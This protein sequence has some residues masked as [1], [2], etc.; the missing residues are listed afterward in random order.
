MITIKDVAERAG[1][2]VATVSRVLNHDG[3]VSAASRQKVINAAETL[4]Y[5]PNLLGR[6]LR[7]KRTNIILVMLASLSNTFCAKVIRGIEK[8]ARQNGYQVLISATGYDTAVEQTDLD[9]VR[10]RLADGVIVLNSTLS[11]EAISE[12]SAQYPLVQCNEYTDTEKTPYISID[13]FAAGYEATTYLLNSGRRHIAF[14]GV[15]E[16]NVS[17]RLRYEGYVKAL[18][19]YGIAPDQRLVFNSNYGYRHTEKV[20]RE[21]LGTKAAFDGLF[22]ISDTMAAAALNT[23]KQEGICVPQDVAVVGFDDTEIAYMTEPALTTIAQPRSELGREALLM[24]LERMNGRPVANRFLQHTLV[25][26]TSA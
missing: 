16:Q 13:N 1:V 10:K 9:L 25:K 3:S 12:F 23:M 14:L 11:A 5:Q 2:S 18:Q 26:R 8:E 17:A 21:F 15:S 24:L 20:M 4:G 6:H 22:A 19:D 7:Q